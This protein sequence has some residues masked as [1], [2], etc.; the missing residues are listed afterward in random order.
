MA[1]R[2]TD[3]AVFDGETLTG[4]WTASAGATAVSVRLSDGVKSAEVAANDNGDGTWTATASADALS[5]LSGAVRWIAYAAGADGTEAIASGSVYVR[6]L[7]SK[8]RAVVA[9]IENALQNWAA[10]PNRQISVGEVSITYKD[11]D[12]LLDILAYWRRRAE[13]DEGGRQPAGG[14]QRI[15]T[16]FA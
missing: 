4:T 6:P 2:F 12:E 10:N 14:V 15:V 5:G 16:R 11:R 7:V 8:H 3:R 13:A 9:A 1:R